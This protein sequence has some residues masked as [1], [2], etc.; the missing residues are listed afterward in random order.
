MSDIELRD[1][2]AEEYRAQDALDFSELPN[3]FQA[4]HF[5]AGWNEARKYQDPKAERLALCVK[6][7]LAQ[8]N[9]KMTV[10]IHKDGAQYRLFCA[11]LKVFEE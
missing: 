5:K 11:A 10:S 7:L 2:L 8:I 6:S 3:V 9:E 1:K 4:V